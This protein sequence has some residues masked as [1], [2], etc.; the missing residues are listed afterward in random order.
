MISNKNIYVIHD[1]TL[2]SNNSNPSNARITRDHLDSRDGEDTIIYKEGP[3]VASGM[4][5]L[6]RIGA[7]SE[8]IWG[9][10][11]KDRLLDTLVAIS[12]NYTPGAAL[13][14]MG[15]SRGAFEVR[16]LVAI[17]RRY[18]IVKKTTDRIQHLKDALNEYYRVNQ[19]Y[20]SALYNAKPDET[21]VAAY[22]PQFAAVHHN[23]NFHAIRYVNS[24]CIFDTVPGLPDKAL[25]EHDI[26]ESPGF[27]LHWVHLMASEVTHLFQNYS[28]LNHP[29]RSRF[30]CGHIEEIGRI[31][32]STMVTTATLEVLG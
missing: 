7:T 4:T 27:V 31:E 3:G 10:E 9:T 15:F 26:H 16:S 18:G 20:Q 25:W 29:D 32:N 12:D 14:F 5:I 2:L 24:L 28:Y 30:R 23:D 17:I 19:M 6:G 8:A 21:T 11:T 13:H 1:G 22:R